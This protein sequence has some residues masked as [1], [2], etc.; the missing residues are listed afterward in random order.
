MQDI[1]CSQLL[2]LGLPPLFS[3]AK[4]YEAISMVHC[5]KNKKLECFHILISNQFELVL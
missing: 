4:T 1:T 3:E 2:P 5:T